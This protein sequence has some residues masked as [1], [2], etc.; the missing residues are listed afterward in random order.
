MVTPKH[1]NLIYDVGLH[2]GEDTDFFL[3]K[4]F[5]VIAIEADPD[6]AQ[7]GANAF[8][9]SVESG[10]LT[11]VHGAV[12]DPAALAG[13]Q[14]TVRFYRNEQLSAW[15]TVDPAWA[16]RNARLGTSSRA[17][18]VP[19]I[20][21]RVVLQSSGIPHYLKVD[22]EGADLICVEALSEF[23]ERPDFVSIESSKTSLREIRRELRVLSALGY[24]RFQAVEQSSLPVRQ[25]PPH[26][27]REGQYASHRFPEG[28]SGLFGAELPEEGWRTRGALLRQY[29]AIMAGYRLLGDD[30]WLT[31]TNVRGAWRLGRVARSVLERL[32]NAPVPGWYD[33]HARHRTVRR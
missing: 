1:A 7:N 19:A 10:Q 11:I 27:P 28:S 4:G 16:D 8:R 20:D 30:G 24:D 2:T 23:E 29:A 25:T 21:M 18:T 9:A 33:T 17:I 32:T 3:Q 6:L 13:G 5:R 26:P 12:V 14:R 22:I 15:G 31:S